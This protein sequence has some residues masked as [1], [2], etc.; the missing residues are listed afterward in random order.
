MTF[1]YAD[2]IDANWA[3]AQLSLAAARELVSSA[4][5]DFVAS[6]AYYAAFYAATALLLSEELT[7][8]KHSGVIASIHRKFVK[9]GR[10]DAQHGKNLNWLFELRGV[11]DFGVE[12]F[13]RTTREDPG[14]RACRNAETDPHA[15]FR[16]LVE[17]RCGSDWCV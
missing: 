7:F 13:R 4:Y 6:R 3:R 8:S 1:K 2:E 12:R 9:T 14:E 15:R 10:L 16:Q 17:E 11:G 5:Y